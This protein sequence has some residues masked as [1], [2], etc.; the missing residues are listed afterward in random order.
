MTGATDRN[1]DTG[2]QAERTQ[3]AWVRTALAAGALAALATRLARGGASLAQ[4]VVLG[5]VV[6][7][8]GAAAALARIRA[9]GR[10]PVPRPAAPW[11]VALLAASLALADALALA[12]LVP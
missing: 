9:L 2:L 1:I 5:L 8:P 10:Q 6:A 12:L 3:L 7:L 4:A 11:T